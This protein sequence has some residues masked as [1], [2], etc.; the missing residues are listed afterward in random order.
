MKLKTS[1]REGKVISLH[2]LF[3]PNMQA[4]LDPK[5]GGA[6]MGLHRRAEEGRA[7]RPHA[8]EADLSGR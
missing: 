6:P 4:S 7:G 8:R 1:I 3:D 2:N 5:M